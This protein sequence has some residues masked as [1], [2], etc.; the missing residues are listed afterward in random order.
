V[1]LQEAVGKG[2]FQGATM[3]TKLGLPRSYRALG[4]GPGLIRTRRTMVDRPAAVSE[5]VAVCKGS[6]CRSH[7]GDRVVCT[8]MK[9]GR[10][11]SR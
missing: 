2:D 9:R 5:Q 11:A 8:E 4:P 3:G 1:C 7:G 6:P 10:L